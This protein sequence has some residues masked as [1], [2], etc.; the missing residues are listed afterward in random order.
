MS[1]RRSGILW[2]G[3]LL[4]LGMGGFVDGIVFHQILQWHHMVTSAGYPPTT[5]HSLEVNTLLDGLFHTLTWLFVAA[6]AVMLWRAG[7]ES[8]L[9]GTGTALLGAGLMGFGAFNFVEGMVNHQILGIHHVNETVP[10][11]RWWQWDAG[12]LV[13][14]AVLFG[15]GLF[16]WRRSV[17]R[18]VRTDAT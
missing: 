1:G 9:R 10:R 14:G 2:S 13:A 8:G 12:F 17:Q 4:G 7:Q 5:V 15:G 11:S 18:G 16:L 6:G 3:L